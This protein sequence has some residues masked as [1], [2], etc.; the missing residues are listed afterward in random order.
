[1]KE[2]PA[3]RRIGKAL[4]ESGQGHLDLAGAAR[5]FCWTLPN[6]T[7]NCRSI[8]WSIGVA[9]VGKNLLAEEA[10]E[11]VVILV[12]GTSSIGRSN[13]G[14]LKTLNIS[15]EYLSMKRSLSW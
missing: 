4:N 3:S 13:W 7:G 15:N 2:R 9:A 1:M 12:L 8:G 6:Q 11:A 5:W 14:W 10:A